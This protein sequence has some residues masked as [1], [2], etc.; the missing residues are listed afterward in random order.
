LLKRSVEKYCPAIA[1]AYR[2]WRDARNLKRVQSRQTA[3]GFHFGGNPSMEDGTFEP[4]ETALLKKLLDKT[5]VFVDV[6]ANIGFYTCLARS[7]GKHVLAVEPLHQNLQYL[8]RNLAANKWDD[9]EVFPVAL[10]ANPSVATL[11]GAST[12][13]SLLNG[14]AGA[15]SQQSQRTAC[16]TMDILIGDRFLGKQLLIKIDVEGFEKLLMDGAVRTLSSSPQPVWL[17]EICLTQNHPSGF[18]RQF[19]ET[20]KVFWSHGY[21]SFSADNV[22]KPIT[23]YDVER[24]IAAKQAEMYNFVF[25]PKTYSQLKP[26][27]PGKA[28]E[29]ERG[30]D[31]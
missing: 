7:M 10:G 21:E 15:S 9:V 8:Y 26:L 14:W 29:T 25:L 13:A 31:S 2:A 1:T 17:L 12:G 27:H 3:H 22:H 5:D 4:E 23:K 20:F 18:N 19:A 6:G 28:I 24:W 30:N 11:F 16:S